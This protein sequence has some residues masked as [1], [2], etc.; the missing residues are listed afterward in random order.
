[1]KWSRKGLSWLLVSLM[2]V[3]SLTACGSQNTPS[4][5]T[6]AVTAAGET[7]AAPTEVSTAPKDPVTIVTSIGSGELTADQIA[8]FQSENSYI[9]I[10]Q[11]ALDGTKLAAEL[12]TGTAPDL[13]Y[14]NGAF[15]LASWVTKGVALDIT[16]YLESSSVIKMDDL[17]PVVNV[18]RFDGKTIGQGPIYGLP[19]DWSNDYAIFYNKRCFDAAGIALPD[20]TKALT[21]PEVL[22]L[23][24]KLTITKDG[25]VTQYGLSATEWG[26]TQP[27]F[28]QMMQYIASAGAKISTDDNKTMNFDKQPVRDYLKMW[29]D[30]CKSNIGPNA[31]NNDQT[32]GGDLFLSDRSAMLIDGF[33]YG[34][35]IRTN[36]NTKT[37]I[38]DFGM[39]PT[40]TAPGGN[41]VA[42]TGGATGCI[43]NKSSKNP[44]AAFKVFEWFFG[45]KPADDRAAT[46][47]GMPI[48]KSKLDLLPQVTNFDKELLAVLKDE[49]DYQQ[50]FLPINPYLAGG[51][52]GIFDKYF[53]PLLFDKSTIDE[54]VK[55]MTDD[56]NVAVSEAINA[57]DNH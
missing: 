9:T 36:D 20:S 28:N 17:L 31:L 2:L 5:T 53:T 50:T 16:K 22:D 1:M 24:K 43:I 8:Q 26:Q 48:F 29:V 56:A 12:A 33:W 57:L 15:E 37:H 41:R 25:K 46:G 40:P 45:G 11:E 47:W 32:S 23:A 19:K 10:K 3:L 49:S 39:L 6:S 13:I 38:D 34:G 55:G 18:Y 54:A 51:G 44:D 52:W 21:W 35:V 4:E 42:A 30:A 7:S 27:N 14:V